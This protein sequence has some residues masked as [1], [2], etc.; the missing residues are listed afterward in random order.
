MSKVL[1]WELSHSTES[2]YQVSETWLP[3]A[4]PSYVS[5]IMHTQTAKLS[6]VVCVLIQMQSSYISGFRN[7]IHSCLAVLVAVD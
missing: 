5:L 4:L 2:C 6:L 3:P 1:S 7:K